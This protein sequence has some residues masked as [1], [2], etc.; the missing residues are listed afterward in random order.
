P[1]SIQVAINEVAWSGTNSDPS[2]EWVE[3]YNPGGL[4]IDLTGWSLVSS[5]VAGTPVIPL[6]GV[7]PAGGYFLLERDQN[8]TNIDADLIYSGALAD[9]GE[10]LSLF[11][12]LNNLIDTANGDGGMWPAG[13]DI[14]HA[15]MERGLHLP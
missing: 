13:S 12:N 1:P 6:S 3:L 2:H 11:D 5:G 4:P 8:A 10:T 15:S 7:I 9:S 14:N